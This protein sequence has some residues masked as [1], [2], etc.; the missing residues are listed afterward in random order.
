MA[1]RGRRAHSPPQDKQ[2]PP[3][4]P[5]A[6]PHAHARRRSLSDPLAAAL[7]PPPNE[8]PEQREQRLRAVEPRHARRGKEEEEDAWALP[9]LDDCLGPDRLEVYNLFFRLTLELDRF[10]THTHGSVIYDLIRL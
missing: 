8:T 6:V 3:Q 9:L 5:L 2:P 1:N 7:L 10:L 4:Q